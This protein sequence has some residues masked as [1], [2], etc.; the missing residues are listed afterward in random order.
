MLNTSVDGIIAINDGQFDLL[1]LQQQAFH[2]RFPGLKLFNCEYLDQVEELLGVNWTLDLREYV[3]DKSLA[4]SIQITKL[5]PL[6][7]NLIAHI[8]NS[9]LRLVGLRFCFVKGNA[10]NTAL[11][12]FLAIR[13]GILTSIS[14]LLTEILKECQSTRVSAQSWSRIDSTIFLNLTRLSVQLIEQGAKPILTHSPDSPAK[15]LHEANMLSMFESISNAILAAE[16]VTHAIGTPFFDKIRL[17]DISL[18]DKF[19]EGLARF[20]LN[21]A[22]KNLKPSKSVTRDLYCECLGFHSGY[23]SIK[24]AFPKSSPTPDKEVFLITGVAMGAVLKFS[25]ALQ[26]TQFGSS[27]ET[28]DTCRSL[29]SDVINIRSIKDTI[30]PQL[31]ITS[32]DKA[33]KLNKKIRVLNEARKRVN[34]EIPGLTD[35][36]VLLTC[37]TKEEESVLLLAKLYMLANV[38]SSTTIKLPYNKDVLPTGETGWWADETTQVEVIKAN[39]NLKLP[40][41]QSWNCDSGCGQC[42]PVLSKEVVETTSQNNHIKKQVQAEIY[43]CNKCGSPVS[44]WDETKQKIL[45]VDFTKGEIWE[46]GTC[47]YQMGTMECRGDGYLWDADNDGYNKHDHS[48][49]CPSCRTQEYLEDAKEHAESTS[50]FSNMSS[51]GSGVDIW[52]WSVKH[53][54]DNN[55][56]AAEQALKKI[57]KVEALLDNPDT[58]EEVLTKTFKY[59]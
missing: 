34:H 25:I 28:H 40:H 52:T 7:Q 47:G 27:G 16:T 53:A 9:Y 59:R 14:Q 45:P 38:T 58:P 51:S 4:E 31:V 43:A 50:S 13:D 42:T 1:T 36:E 33:L 5:H 10:P 48:Y 29:V 32:I 2:K 23:Q 22:E 6:I 54:L 19:D 46:G 12:D 35:E 21:L 17:S 49:P 26:K 55:R 44:V 18:K 30:K 8:I 3:Q 41:H 56:D 39:I 20:T 57:G 24:W 15:L 37:F 11:T